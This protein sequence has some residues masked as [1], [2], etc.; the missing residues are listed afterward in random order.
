MKLNNPYIQ[1]KRSRIHGDGVYAKKNIPVATD[2]IQYVGEKITKE[3]S[4]ERAAAV[5]EKAKKTGSGSVYIFSLDDE[6]DIDG[7]V[8]WNPARLINHACETN[9]EAQ[10]V[11]DEIWI[12]ATKNIKK[13]EE[14]H[15]DYGYD[16]DNWRDHPCRCGSDKCIGVIVDEKSR[17]KLMRTRAYKAYIAKSS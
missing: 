2:I 11:D 3:E 16:L 12:V 8:S 15:Y 4:E 7:N 9:C 14:L 6:Y 5:A 13:G 10:I 17:K 1:I